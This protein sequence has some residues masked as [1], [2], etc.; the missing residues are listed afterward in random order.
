MTYFFYMNVG[1]TNLS[2]TPSVSFAISWPACYIVTYDVF[3]IDQL[4]YCIHCFQ[5]SSAFPALFHSFGAKRNWR[6]VRGCRGKTP[7]LR[8]SRNARQLKRSGGALLNWSIDVIFGK[9]RTSL[10]FT[11]HSLC[12]WEIRHILLIW[13]VVVSIAFGGQ[14]VFLFES[15]TW[16]GRSIWSTMPPAA[17]LF[18][19]AVSVSKLCCV[20]KWM[21]LVYDRSH[22]GK[23]VHTFSCEALSSGKA[24]QSLPRSRRRFKWR[25]SYRRWSSLVTS[26]L[27]DLWTS[28]AGEWRKRTSTAGV[29]LQK[30][31]EVFTRARISSSWTKETSSIPSSMLNKQLPV[32]SEEPVKAILQATLSLR[33]VGLL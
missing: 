5:P 33:P 15:L 16:P 19:S 11:C 9:L 25:G 8:A 3:Y 17:Y 6:S 12:S 23:N 29:C 22:A 7:S 20:C 4:N 31:P 30:T 21:Q 10:V 24:A 27:W 18:A 26:C 32:R 28:V 14:T 2:W 1:G 13:C